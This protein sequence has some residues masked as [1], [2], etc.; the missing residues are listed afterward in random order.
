MYE[1]VDEEAPCILGYFSSIFEFKEEAFPFTLC[2]HD[3]FSTF[4]SSYF[5]YSCYY[6]LSSLAYSFCLVDGSSAD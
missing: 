4:G 1:N 5:Y 3:T 6:V 2:I